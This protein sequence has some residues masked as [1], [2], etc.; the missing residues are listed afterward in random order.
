MK[1]FPNKG[2]AANVAKKLTA[3]TG[4][5]HIAI[6]QNGKWH[7]ID[8]TAP[9]EVTPELPTQMESSPEV[10]AEPKLSKS[11]DELVS[12]VIAGAK[13]SKGYVYTPKLNGKSRW[14]AVKSLQE[15]TDIEG[16]LKLVAKR[17]VFASRGIA[18]LIQEEVAA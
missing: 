11:Q 16:G 8:S 1:T 15:A 10:A 17:K 7:V 5:D 13:L 3:K 9:V 2:I 4:N 14:F 6:E 12:M 18:D